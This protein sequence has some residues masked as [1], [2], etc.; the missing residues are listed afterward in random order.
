M[1]V[2]AVT[3][4]Q[5]SIMLNSIQGTDL[6]GTI[7]LGIRVRPKE[8]PEILELHH[9]YGYTR[10]RCR[11]NMLREPHRLAV[12]HRMA[13]RNRIHSIFGRDN[14][15]G[16]DHLERPYLRLRTLARYHAGHRNYL[17]CYRFQHVS[18]QEAANGRGTDIDNPYRGLVRDC[19]TFM[20]AC[21]KEYCQ[22]RL[23]RIQ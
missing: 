12:F 13:V 18:G 4:Y 22:S 14:H 1:S 10:Y 9:R 5:G 16:F 19:D 2:N 6:R 3:M 17:L 23:H 20:G 8:L 11:R 15:T 21:T 7:S